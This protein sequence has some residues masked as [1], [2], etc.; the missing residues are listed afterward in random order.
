M[1][2]DLFK[3]IRRLEIEAMTEAAK[4][5]DVSVYVPSAIGA[6]C[7]ECRKRIKETAVRVEGATLCVRCAFD[8][9]NRIEE[10]RK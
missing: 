6:K 1:D 3:Q 8:E 7:A 4:K 5:P 2:L 9:V 10:K